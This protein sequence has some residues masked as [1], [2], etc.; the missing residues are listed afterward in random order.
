MENIDDNVITLFLIGIILFIIITLFVVRKSIQRL[1]N[2][3]NHLEAEL[4][5]PPSKKNNK[6]EEESPE[7]SDPNAVLVSQLK[8]GDVLME[9]VKTMDGKRLLERGCKISEKNIARL[10]QW[11]IRV[12]KIEK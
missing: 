11:H 12:V 10:K 3:I 8:P 9:D 2:N 5:K 7:L 6:K 4:K 1:K